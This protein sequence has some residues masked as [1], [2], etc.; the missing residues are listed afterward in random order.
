MDDVTPAMGV[1][2]RADSG[3]SRTVR[4]TLRPS[5][6]SQIGSSVVVAD[7]RASSTPAR[8]EAKLAQ[9]AL[10]LI[11]A[12]YRVEHNAKDE[13]GRQPPKSLLGVAIRYTL[14]QWAELG[15]FLDDA[16]VPF[17]NN[18]SSE[19]APA[20]RWAARTTFSLATSTRGRA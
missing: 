5:I 3:S 8:P 15:V 19:R 4:G 13:A 2:A 20:S 16:R 10:D 9:E 6:A 17:D 1:R 18:A 14:A 11:T 12:L 7:G